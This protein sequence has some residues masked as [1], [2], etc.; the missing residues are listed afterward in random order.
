MYH[1]YSLTQQY[2]L[3]QHLL[4]SGAVWIF[5]LIRGIVYFFQVFCFYLEKKIKIVWLQKVKNCQPSS[6]VYFSALLLCCFRLAGCIRLCNYFSYLSFHSGKKI[7]RKPVLN[8]IGYNG[9]QIKKV[10]VSYKLCKYFILLT[11]LPLTAVA[12]FPSEKSTFTSRAFLY[13]P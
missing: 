11:D 12:V 4:T 5:G 10:A 9:L 8:A 3:T 1:W 6:V 2:S 13:P 7:P